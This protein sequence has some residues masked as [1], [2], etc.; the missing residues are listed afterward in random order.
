VTDFK[1]GVC[2]MPSATYH[3]IEA[4]SASGAKK[5]LR[6][7]QHYMLMRTTPNVPTAAMQF[8][9]A[10]HA[11]VLE[12]DTFND[13]V[14]VA[15]EVNKRSKDGKAEHE[16]FQAAN[17]GKVILSADDFD[18]VL[19][20]A[21]AVRAHP[22]AAKLLS[23]GQAEASLFW[24]DGKYRVPC[25]A[26]YDYMNLGGIVDLKTCVDASAEAFAKAVANYFYHLQAAFYCSGSE[27]VRN[28]SPQFFAFVAV[29]SEPPHGVACYVLPGNAI[30]AGA[31]LA[32]IALERYAAAL[33]A[34]EW[35]GYSDAIEVLQ[36]P[37]WATTFRV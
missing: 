7:P 31:H 28:E 5:M 23:G 37:K 4:M 18:R 16:A 14:V 22:A 27:H 1:E 24:I 25:K 2:A 35:P 20:C 21:A 19:A 29:E 3:S 11:L 34:N 9:T 12:P 17:A 10:V 32:N 33:A 26:R 30:L 6:S 36:L 8:G 13:A 15:P